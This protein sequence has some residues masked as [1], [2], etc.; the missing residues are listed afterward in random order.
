MAYYSRKILLIKQNYNIID[1]ELLTIVAIF[2]E[3]YVYIK[4]VVE[5]TVYINHK[6]LLL[7]TIIK[8]FNRR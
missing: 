6:N 3:W 5:T 2:E 8:E 1:K 4:G 7:F